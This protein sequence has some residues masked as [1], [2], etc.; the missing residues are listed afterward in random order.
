LL[1]GCEIVEGGPDHKVVA[2]LVGTHP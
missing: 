1:S 2:I